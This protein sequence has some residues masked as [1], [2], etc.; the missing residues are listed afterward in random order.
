MSELPAILSI[1][2]GFAALL[3][4]AEK[5][6]EGAASLALHVGIPEILVG[7]LIVG[8]GTSSPEILVSIL[9]SLG[10]NSGLLLG[11]AYGSNVANISL[12]LGVT[13][14]ILPILVEKRAAHRDI[15]V[16]LAFTAVGTYQALDGTITRTESLVLL[17][18]FGGFI[19]FSL[20]EARKNRRA[21]EQPEIPETRYSLGQSVFWLAVG[22]VVLASSSRLLVWGAVEISRI[23]GVSDLIIG[24]TVVAFGTSLPE[25]SA[26]LAAAMKKK[27]GISVG[28][29]IGSNLFNT[30]A[31]VGIG[32]VIA[33][34]PAGGDFLVRD[35]PL[36]ALFT[37]VLFLFC[38]GKRARVGR[39]KGGILFSSYLAYVAYLVFQAV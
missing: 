15:P 16:L 23:L 30:M 8:F 29:V 25:L 21:T 10:G 37:V 12:I 36:N 26:S 35:L 22:L 18:L 5:M 20:R 1:L 19:W 3:W 31:V 7:M 4:S 38:L 32:G 28:N 14:L 17:S 24:L 33:E 39:F 9:S 34:I 2:G 6:V 13:A 11:N 27:H